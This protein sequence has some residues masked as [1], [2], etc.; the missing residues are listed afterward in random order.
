MLRK[1]RD[2]SFKTCC[3][4]FRTSFWATSSCIANPY[5]ELAVEVNAHSLIRGF[6]FKRVTD[7]VTKLN[8]SQSTTEFP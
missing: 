1:T 7:A 4:T 3:K 6:L 5:E 2:V 8:P